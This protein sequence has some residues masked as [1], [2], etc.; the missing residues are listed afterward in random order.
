M[1]RLEAATIRA[2]GAIT[3]RSNCAGDRLPGP[4][5]EQLHRL[6]AGLDLAGQI[7]DRDRLDPRR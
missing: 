6:D 4:A 2:V 3:Q 1:P 5:V 7:V